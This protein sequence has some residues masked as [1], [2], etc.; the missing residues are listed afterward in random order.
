MHT[1]RNVGIM[2]KPNAPQAVLLVPA[3]FTWFENRGIGIRF[4]E[5]T[6]LYAGRKDWVA[7][8]EVP[9]N[10]EL[11]IVLGGD[12]TIL[13]ASRAVPGKSHHGMSSGYS[14]GKYQGYSAVV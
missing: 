7:R 2:S 9:R 13:S 1:I 8:E 3:L 14:A 11:L 4:D 6:G 12:G 10:I 5:N